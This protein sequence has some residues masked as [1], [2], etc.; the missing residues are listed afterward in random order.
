[1]S[2]KADAA[3]LI[4]KLLASRAT[5][6]DE[7]PKLIEN[8]QRALSN[9]GSPVATLTAT[10]PAV[11]TPPVPRPRARAKT[12]PVLRDVSPSPVAAMQAPETKPPQPVLLR[13]AASITAA[14]SAPAPLFAALSNGMVRGLVQ[15]F[16]SRTGQGALRLAG[17]SHDVPVD[18]A[19]LARFG[20]TRLFKGQEIEAMLKGAG[21]TL[22]ISALQLANATPALPVTGGMVRDRHAKPVVVELKREHKR[23]STARAEAEILLR[24]R[25]VR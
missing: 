8:V 3:R 2:G 6:L 7:V 25:R 22:K 14:P 20:I 13:R 16:D 15:W 4:A 18:A 24:P 17:L 19:S 12:A 5:S 11:D 23:R 10:L 9:L 1:M 21:E